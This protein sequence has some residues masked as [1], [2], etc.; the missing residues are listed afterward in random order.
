VKRLVMIAAA[1]T[2]VAGLGLLLGSLVAG[3]RDTRAYCYSYTMA[4]C[5]SYTKSNLSG[6][7]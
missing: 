7:A 1:M 4:Y 2:R 3:S 6:C 5:Y